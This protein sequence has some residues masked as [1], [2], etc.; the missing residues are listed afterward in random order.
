[1]RSVFDSLDGIDALADKF[2]TITASL[3]KLNALQ[4]QLAGPDPTAARRSG[5]QPRPA[6]LQLRHH[7]A[8]TPR[9]AEA[10]ETATAMGKAFDDA[11]NDDSFYLPPEA[12][13]NPDFKRGLKLFMSP[14]GHA[15]RMTITHEGNPAT[16]RGHLAH[17]R[18]SG[19][20]PSTRSRPPRWPTPK[21]TSP[22]PRRPTRTFRT[23]RN[24]T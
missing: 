18:R 17:R 16:A 13:D 14:D 11:K 21:S 23:A 12:F 8:P 2:G 5:S 15:V 20:R 19:T 4:P 9:S 24:T 7:G 10:L 22:A 3:D 1:M 6:A